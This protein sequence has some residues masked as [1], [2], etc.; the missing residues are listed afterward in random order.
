MCVG[1]IRSLRSIEGSMNHHLHCIMHLSL[2]IYFHDIDHVCTAKWVH[3]PK[4]ISTFAGL[5]T[6]EIR[7]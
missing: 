7:R 5:S 4:L 6:V 3:V 2:Y 1:V